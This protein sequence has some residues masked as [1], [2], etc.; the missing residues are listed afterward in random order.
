MIDSDTGAQP[1]EV[2]DISRP[3]TQDE[4][5]SVFERVLDDG[6]DEDK[7]EQ[8]AQ[9]QADE[10]EADPDQE[11]EAE[12]DEPEANAD[13]EEED[14]AEDQ[15][16]EQPDEPKEL[17]LSQEV[18][19]PNG[20]KVTLEELQKGYL[21]QDDYTRKSMRRAEAEKAVEAER[22]QV[23]AYY[24]SVEQEAQQ[25]AGV[26]QEAL[27]T[28]QE[29][30]PYAAKDLYAKV[31]QADMQIKQTRQQRS[32]QE[33][34]MQEQH[35]QRVKTDNIS[36][37]QALAPELFTQKGWESFQSNAVSAMQAVGY[38]QQEVHGILS[39]ASQGTLDPRMVAMLNLAAK[40]QALQT[41]RPKVEAKTKAAK[42]MR[43][44][45]RRSAK[46]DAAQRYAQKVERAKKTGRDD[47][48]AA[49]LMEII[50]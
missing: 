26:L 49:A 35:L 2:S 25:I 4:A 9:A 19:L 18:S 48:V 44:S 24:Q 45:K 21:R 8:E 23:K 46:D 38:S 16:D 41:N 28:M 20:E 15:D 32:E 37:M 43:S 5:V 22:Q 17:D 31:Q 33:R 10:P 34:Q 27:R 1:T 39:Q 47:D 6:P 42:P 3:L 29:L 11:P 36:T 14:T 12:A 50:D 13:D 30:D 40:Q 7:P